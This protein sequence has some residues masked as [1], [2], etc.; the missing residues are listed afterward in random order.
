M[1]SASRRWRRV[2]RLGYCQD[3]GHYRRITVVRFW[4]NDMRYRVCAQCIR[5][6]RKVILT[7]HAPE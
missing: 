2:Y 7:R 1:V 4:L 5:P 3:C 6:Y